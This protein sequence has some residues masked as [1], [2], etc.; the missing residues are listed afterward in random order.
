MSD[1]LPRTPARRFRLRIGLALVIFGL[2][3]FVLGAQPALFSLDRS[4]VTGFLQIAVLLIGL[5]LICLGGYMT[6]NTLWNGRQKSIAADVGLRL[7]STGYVI[8]VASGMADV[9]GFGTHRFPA[10][11]YFGPWQAVG[12]I[13]GEIIITIGFFLLIPFPQDEDAAEAQN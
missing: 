3:V 12:V 9:F 8:S 13:I 2:I 10:I 1:T 6:L 11:P 5:A 4:P 7:V